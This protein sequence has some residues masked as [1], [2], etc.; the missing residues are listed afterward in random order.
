MVEEGQAAAGA[1]TGGL[2]NRGVAARQV[3]QGHNQN[4]ILYRVIPILE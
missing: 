1:P 4:L 3:G 2:T